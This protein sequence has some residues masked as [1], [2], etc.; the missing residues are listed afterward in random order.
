MY[1]L[2]E[3]YFSDSMDKEEIYQKENMTKNWD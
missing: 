2:V 1:N 3:I